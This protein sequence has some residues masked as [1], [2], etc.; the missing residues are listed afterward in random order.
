[1]DS[2]MGRKSFQHFKE[3]NLILEKQNSPEKVSKKNI[4]LIKPVY[5]GSATIIITL[6]KLIQPKK[7]KTIVHRT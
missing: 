4:R 6:Q 3:T 7:T 1:M 2:I 5:H